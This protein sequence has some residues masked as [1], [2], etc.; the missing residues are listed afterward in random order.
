MNTGLVLTVNVGPAAPTEHS[1]VGFTGIDKR[2]VTARVA[3]EAQAPMGEGASGL[4]G[5]AVCDLD[6]H[7][8]EYQAVYAY[9]RE[10]YDHWE[11]ELGRALANGAFGDNL[12]TSGL[13]L[14]GAVVGSTWRIGDDGLVCRVTA[15]RIPCRTFAAH[16]GEERWVKR[17]TQHGATGAYLKVLEP[18]TVGAGDRIEVL[19]V[20]AHGVTV[21][22]MFR[23]L[24]TQAE[25]LP[26]LTAI[27]D[28]HP[29]AA[30]K[31]RSRGIR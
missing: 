26:E 11:A 25:L 13:D 9:A 16:V 12:T 6:F 14:V 23:A 17:F 5:D 7:G 24:T 10:N 3:V 20:P 28:L 27:A 29:V 31:M 8:G 19:D 15:P 22:T 2:P 1:T 4:A 18:G 30:E 21:G